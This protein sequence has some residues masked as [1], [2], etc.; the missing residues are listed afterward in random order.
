MKNRP[1]REEWKEADRRASARTRAWWAWYTGGLGALAPG[2]KAS[3]D[4]EAKKFG[5]PGVDARLEASR[6]KV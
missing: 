4:E 6:R 3:L 2:L 1:T 5:L